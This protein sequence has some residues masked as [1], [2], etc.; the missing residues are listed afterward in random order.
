MTKPKPTSGNTE[1]TEKF[2]YRMVDGP[3]P[4]DYDS[5]EGDTWP[6]PETVPAKGYRKGVYVKVFESKGTAED[7]VTARGAVYEWL[8]NYVRPKEEKDVNESRN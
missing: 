6:L 1:D 3:Y 7:G 2:I 4:G 8:P 5:P